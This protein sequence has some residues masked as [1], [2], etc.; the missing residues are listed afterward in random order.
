MP[1]IKQ[2][3]TFVVINIVIEVSVKQDISTSLSIKN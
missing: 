3:I 1:E 2:G